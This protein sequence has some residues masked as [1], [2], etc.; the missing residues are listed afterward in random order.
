MISFLIKIYFKMIVS[1]W[2]AVGF[3]KLLLV[4]I[5]LLPLFG[6]FTAITLALDKFLYPEF[7]R[8]VIKKPV[9]IIGHPRSGTTFLHRLIADDCF[10]EFKFWQIAFPSL[11][12]RKILQPFIDYILKSKKNIM[13]SKKNVLFPVEVGHKMELDDVEEEELLFFHILNTQF[14]TLISPIGFSDWDFNELVYNDLQPEEVREKS[15]DFFRGCLQRQAYYLQRTQVVSKINY[16][17]M[18]LKS[19]FHA[20]PDARVIY[21]VRSP[22]E[23]QN[24]HFSLHRNIFNHLWGLDKLRDKR[25][26]PRYYQRRYQHNVAFYSYLEDLL[27]NGSVPLN[28]ILVLNYNEMRDDP[29]NALQQFFSFTGIH[30]S[31][32][33]KQK[34][35]SQLKNQKSYQ[36]KHRNIDLTEFGISKEQIIDDLQAVF[37]K[38]GFSV[39]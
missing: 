21:L 4:R 10:V 19:L 11:T 14:L 15:M 18:R 3:G 33:L 27:E 20:F 34:I 5:Y 38:Y 6:I 30:P 31:E 35:Q 22:L 8:V 37:K 16:S 24:S 9:F 1:S 36:A 12:G 7:Q 39:K 32:R 26:L 17:G 13:K 28:Q 23:T 2:K 25:M 29:E